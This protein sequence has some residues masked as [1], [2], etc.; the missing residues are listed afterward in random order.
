MEAERQQ[1]RVA[2][3]LEISERLV[4]RYPES[5]EAKRAREEAQ[6]IRNDPDKLRLAAEHAADRL[7]GLYLNLAEAW[8]SQGRPQQGAFYL[9]KVMVT[10]PGSRH[11]E[12]AQARLA[13]V[14]GPPALNSAAR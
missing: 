5:E 2:G 9:E 8:I 10:F 11:A 1:G 4:A 7:A 14:Q 13:Q 6:A 12:A 3:L